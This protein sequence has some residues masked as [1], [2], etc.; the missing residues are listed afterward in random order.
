MNETG[1][2]PGE[3]CNLRED[4]IHLSAEVP[5]IRIEPRDDPQDPREIKTHSS[6]CQIPLVGVALEVFR[7]HHKGFPRYRDNETTLS[8]TLNRFMR[9]KELWPSEKA[10]VYSIRHGFED[11]MKEGGWTRSCGESS[12]ALD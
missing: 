8:A 3:L 6:I 1:A 2:R 7:K 12:W 4:Y 9:D 10:T 11:R 5:Y